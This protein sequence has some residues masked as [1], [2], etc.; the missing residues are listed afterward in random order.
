MGGDEIQIAS[1][2]GKDIRVVVKKNCL[3]SS[4]FSAMDRMVLSNTLKVIE[5]L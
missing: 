4:V 2:F 5:I 1:G 3:S